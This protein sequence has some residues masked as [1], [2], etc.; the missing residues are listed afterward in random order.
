M[1]AD[2]LTCISVKQARHTAVVVVQ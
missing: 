2:S 1:Q